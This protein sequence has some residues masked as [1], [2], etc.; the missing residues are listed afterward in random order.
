[1]PATASTP[2]ASRASTSVWD[3]MPPA[4]MSCLAVQARR[5]A[6]TSRGKPCMVPSVSTWV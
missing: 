1:M 2:M 5:M 3:L 4:T 6:A